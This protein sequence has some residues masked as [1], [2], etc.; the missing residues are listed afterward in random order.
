MASRLSSPLPSA[1]ISTAKIVVPGFI[2]LDPGTAAGATMEENVA[3][4]QEKHH[5]GADT[6]APMIEETPEASK[7]GEEETLAKT[8][9]E[10]ERQQPE[11]TAD[12]PE[13]PPSPPPQQ[14]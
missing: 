12:Q 14:Q 2:N 11:M 7:L 13:A 1:T 10:V 9:V 3:L 6:S 5:G 8:S 4:E